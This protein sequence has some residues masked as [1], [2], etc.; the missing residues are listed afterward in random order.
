MYDKHKKALEADI[1][2]ISIPPEDV[3]AAYKRI[4]YGYLEAAYAQVRLGRPCLFLRHSPRSYPLLVNGAWYIID[5]IHTQSKSLRRY[6]SSSQVVQGDQDYVHSSSQ[7][8]QG[9]QD[10]L[11]VDLYFH[12]KSEDL[13]TFL[14]QDKGIKTLC[15]TRMYKN[16]PL[17]EFNMNELILYNYSGKYRENNPDQYGCDQK[18]ISEALSGFIESK[19]IAKAVRKEIYA[20][21]SHS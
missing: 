13:G 21:I 8:V 6:Q 15:K 19:I 3:Q 1:Q 5:D 4:G 20:K 9:D 14:F 11:L 12:Q 18:V 2:S 10:Y 17:N 16:G 7:V